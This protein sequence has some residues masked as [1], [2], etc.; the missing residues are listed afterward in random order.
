MNRRGITGWIAR[1]TL[2]LLLAATGTL[3][4]F[5]VLP[6][7][8]TIGQGGSTDMIVRSAEVAALPP[9]PPPQVEQEPEEEEPE[10]EPP[11]EL[12]EEAP[13]LELSQLELALNTDIG[14]DAFGDFAVKL[15][16]EFNEGGSEEL[17][18]MFSL[19]DLDQPPRVIF[20]RMP[21]YPPE[22]RKRKRR[23]TV[24]VEFTVDVRGRVSQP[25]VK[26]STDPAFEAPALEAVKQWRFEPGTRNGE[27]VAFKTMVPITF[28]PT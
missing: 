7:M 12:L 15:S 28:S 17:D 1:K 11:P 8:Q 21:A 16:G 10:E 22:L 26:K 14:A 9:P 25:K 18:R 27:A 5:L 4:V 2:V 6:V 24:H 13:P 19:Q 20:Q 23:G 3:A